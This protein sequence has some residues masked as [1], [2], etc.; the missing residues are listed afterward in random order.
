MQQAA[1]VAYAHATLDRAEAFAAALT[2]DLAR[3]VALERE[4]MA[5]LAELTACGGRQPPF[6]DPVLG[7]SPWKFSS[8]TNYVAFLFELYQQ[9]SPGMIVAPALLE[10]AAEGLKR[11]ALRRR[12]GLPKG[13]GHE[14]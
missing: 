4:S 5:I 9:I 8:D 11:P 13:A 3:C 6:C 2:R 7:L 1:S 14:A 12:W 10:A